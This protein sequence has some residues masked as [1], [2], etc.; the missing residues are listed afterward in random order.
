MESALQA[1]R[2]QSSSLSDLFTQQR[3]SFRHGSTLSFG[4]SLL[5]RQAMGVHFRVFRC[6]GDL[7]AQ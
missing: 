5:R 4:I 2:V 3:P 6:D 7:S 1:D